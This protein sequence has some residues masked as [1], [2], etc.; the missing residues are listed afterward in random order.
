MNEPEPPPP[1]YPPW[2]KKEILLPILGVVLLGLVGG[3]LLVYRAIM[4]E[5]RYV[6]SEFGPMDHRPTSAPASTNA[7]GVTN[8]PPR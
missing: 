6:P 7:T 1:K 8:P 5:R 4:K 3:N 2:V